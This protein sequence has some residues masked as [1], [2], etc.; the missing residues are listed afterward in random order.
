[1]AS[2]VVVALDT[3]APDLA[4]ET[5]QDSGQPTLLTVALTADPDTIEV[6]LWG[7]I[8]ITD[9]LNGD[10]A[11]TEGDAPWIEFAS[12]LQVRA[13]VGGSPIYARVRD[14]V[15]NESA[16]A[17]VFGAVTPPEQVPPQQGGLPTPRRAAP[18]PSTRTVRTTTRVRVDS[19][20]SVHK[21]STRSHRSGSRLRVRS[22][23]RVVHPEPVRTRSSR[24]RLNVT[25]AVGS[26]LRSRS[27]V[28]LVSTTR[29]VGVRAEGPDAEAALSELE[30][31]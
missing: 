29:R 14:D 3:T 1:M 2:H 18:R 10:Y 23:T 21:T 16:Q 4:V 6:K 19:R 13:A 31:L 26:T 7:G 24:V 17:L 12:P 15:H 28:A 20:T 11:E 25:T 30:I 5:E 22:R 8:D 27:R 9:P